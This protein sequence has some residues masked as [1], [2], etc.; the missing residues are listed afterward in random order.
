MTL[1]DN[2]SVKEIINIILKNQGC[3]FEGEKEK[4]INDAVEMICNARKAFS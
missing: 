3:F 2:P 1:V 4:T